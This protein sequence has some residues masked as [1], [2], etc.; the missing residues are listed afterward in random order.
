MNPRH[1]LLLNSAV[2]FL[3]A[4]DA[5]G[6]SGGLHQ[7][8]VE[9]EEEVYRYE[10][11]NN[12]A[13]PLWCHGSTTLVRLGETVFATGLETLTDAAPCSNVDLTGFE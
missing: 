4:L 13:G 5:V 1:P 6:A 10:P 8:R 2:A 11:A 3:L 9:V 7:L 12:G